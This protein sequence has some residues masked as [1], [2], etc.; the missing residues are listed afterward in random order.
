MSWCK[1][2]YMGALSWLNAETLERA[3][4]PVFGRL[5]RCS[6]H[7]RSIMRLQYLFYHGLVKERPPPTFGPISCTGSMFTQ[8]STHPGASFAWSLRSTA[9]S[10]IC[11]S[12]VRNFTKSYYKASLHRQTQLMQCALQATQC[13]QGHGAIPSVVCHQD[14]TSKLLVILLYVTDYLLEG[15]EL[16]ST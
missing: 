1:H 6:T 9:S 5:V 14:L 3:P 15:I 8:M 10:A 4:T 2:T 13:S 12:E 11:I 16:L 7:G